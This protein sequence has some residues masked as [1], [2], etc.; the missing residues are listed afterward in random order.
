MS[1]RSPLTDGIIGSLIHVLLLFVSIF[2]P[3]SFISLMLLPLPALVYTA[4]HTRK[5]GAVFACISAALGALFGLLWLLASFVAAGAGWGMG[6]FHHSKRRSVRGLLLTGTVT[7]LAGISLALLLLS[8][9]FDFHLG[10]ILERQWEQTI[11]VYTEIWDEMGIAVNERELHVVRETVV[12]LL[13]AVFIVMAGSTA[14]VNHAIGRVVLRRLEVPTVKLPPFQE[15]HFP[16]SLLAWYIVSVVVMLLTEIG[17]YWY[18]VAVTAN[19]LITLLFVVQALS[20]LTALVQRWLRP[21]DA[22]FWLGVLLFL[23]LFVFIMLFFFVPLSFLGMLD[24]GF[25]FRDRLQKR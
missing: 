8:V 18:S 15:W 25:R 4:K 22:W 3:L 19:W 17:S 7:L 5:A 1:E 2:T 24:I 21:P 9:S 14:L 20:L 12:S 23:P 13:P 6:Q 11:A 16:R 10:S